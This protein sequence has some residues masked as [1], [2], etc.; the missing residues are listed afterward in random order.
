MWRGTA[1]RFKQTADEMMEQN[2]RISEE[3][4][5][6]RSENRKLIEDVKRLNTMVEELKCENKGLLR[7]LNEIKK[8]QQ[9]HETN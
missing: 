7:R 2:N 6:L 1:E 8:L 4:R 9:S 3:V 5:N